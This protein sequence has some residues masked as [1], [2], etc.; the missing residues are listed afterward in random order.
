MLLRR[1][2]FSLLLS[3]APLAASATDYPLQLQNCGHTLK[4]DKAPAS[5]VTIGQAGTEMLYALG[6]GDRV[7]GTS[8]WFNAVQPQFKAIDDKVPRLADNDPSFEAVIGKRPALV[9][10][11]FEWMVGKEG[12]VGTR[13]QFHDLRIATYA[14]PSDCEG[15]NNLSGADGTRTAAYDVNTL[16][17]SIQQLAQIFDVEA[18]GQALVQELRQRQAKA[19]TQ[20]QS[21]R[22]RNMSAALWFSSADLSIDPYMAGQKGVAGYMLQTLGLRNIVTSAEEWP[23]VG[24]ETIAKA[25][26]SMLIIA[27]M[28]RRRFP[29]DDYR[30]KLEFLKKDPVTRHMDAVKNNRIVIVDADA[31]QGSIRMVDGIEQIAQA[32]LELQAPAR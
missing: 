20:L 21:P 8:L 6:L 13:E 16:Y 32:A 27:R 7:S 4:F 25:N 30:K 10:S 9:V 24:W 26:P 5:A 3:A 2:A 15:K 11:Q 29:A 22:L 12:V 23:T 28:D 19:V 17:K 14:M 18:R 31:L 1:L